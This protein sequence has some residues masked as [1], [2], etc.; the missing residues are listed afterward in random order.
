ML[1]KVFFAKVLDKEPILRNMER[2]LWKV[3]F[4]SAFLGAPLYSGLNDIKISMSEELQSAPPLSYNLPPRYPS[5]RVEF[6]LAPM[7]ESVSVI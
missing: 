4:D 3:L 2:R 6:P 5:A 1:C 7:L